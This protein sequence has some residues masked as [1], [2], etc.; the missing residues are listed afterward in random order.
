MGFH[1][2]NTRGVH[3]QTQTLGLFFFFCLKRQETE[4][5]AMIPRS[6]HP[7]FFVVPHRAEQEKAGNKDGTEPTQSRSLESE[8]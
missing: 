1:P 4:I 3:T 6:S 2:I 5:V 8:T 7:R